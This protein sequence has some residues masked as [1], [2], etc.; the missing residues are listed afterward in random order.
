MFWITKTKYRALV[1]AFSLSLLI[2]VCTCL[3]S[4][5]CAS[6]DVEG[7]VHDAEGNP[8]EGARIILWRSRVRDET[9]TDAEGRYA[10]STSYY[11]RSCTVYAFYDDPR[12]GGYDFLPSARSYGDLEDLEGLENFTLRPAATVEV[13]GQLR[14]VEF[15][16]EVTEYAFSVVDPVYGAL[17]RYDDCGL[18]YGPSVGSLATALGLPP[19]SVAVPAETPF[20]IRVSPPYEA[21]R[22][23]M[24]SSIMTGYGVRDDFPEFDIVEDGGFTLGEGEVLRLDVSKYCL[25]ND[26]GKVEALIERVEGNLT[27]FES[28]GF[29]TAPQRHQLRASRELTESSRIQLSQGMYDDSY[30]DLKEAWLKL[31]NINLKMEGLLAEAAL[32]V[33]VLI[34]FL[35]LTSYS[36]STLLLDSNS[37]KTILS[38]LLFVPMLA[39]LYYVYPGSKAVTLGWFAAVSVVSLVVIL[40]ATRIRPR[41]LN[42]IKLGDIGLLDAVVSVS[43]I[44]KRNLR[45]RR[46]RSGLTLA[47]LLALTMSFVA[48]TSMSSNYGLIY[49]RLEG[50]IPGEDGLTLRNPTYEPKAIYVEKGGGEE[51]GDRM[52]SNIDAGNFHPVTDS[53]VDW[54]L[55]RDDVLGVTSRAESL[56]SIN[57]YLSIGSARVNGVVG[58][59]TEDL[60]LLEGLDECVVEG[61]PLREGGTCL[62]H[63]SLIAKNVTQVGGFLTLYDR[64]TTPFRSRPSSRS[65]YAS[66]RLEVVGAFDDGLME[67]RDTDG[68]GILPQRHEVTYYRS[69]ALVEAVPCSPQEVVVT[70]LSTAMTLGD[71][72][73]SRLVMWLSSGSDPEAVGKGMALAREFRIWVSEVG[74][75]HLAFMGEAIAGKGLPLLIPWGIV[76]LNVLTTM[77]NSM[78]ERKKEINIL[79]SIG[80][81]PL[82]ISGVFLA[83]AMIMGVVAGGL[84]YILGL[85]WYPFMAQLQWAPD[86]QQKISAKWSLAA[87]G[88]SVASVTIGSILAMRG[89]V[90]LTPSLRRRWGIEELEKTHDDFYIMP[91]PL[92]VEEENLYAFVNFTDDYVRGFEDVE[93]TPY[94]IS[95]KKETVEDEGHPRYDI[96]FYYS[97]SGSIVDR[98]FV[99]N[100]IS[101]FRGSEEEAYSVVLKS[102]G[103][104]EAAQQVGAFARRMAFEWA[105]QKT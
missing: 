30:V 47:T 97:E 12:T 103:E 50:R 77:L 78:Y 57:S 58:V 6:P 26:L 44:A 19:N 90:V 83:E 74:S 56:P 68:G 11:S 65:G 96:S 52:W 25:R 59:D 99:Y 60:S 10:L 14:P 72:E 105:A 8:I 39:F 73:V 40:T 18:I 21:E 20:V 75:V 32:S 3:P 29:Y 51:G 42:S 67:V 17:L 92:Q 33:N 100:L 63:V 79:S 2:L 24:W 49:T 28:E 104:K 87:I 76:V 15:S 7:Y 48:L 27:K 31:E 89:S 66:H 41:A 1:L 38:G 86:V 69:T 70:T 37:G 101:I 81:N 35:A 34:V 46:I 85:G 95:V 80:L 4:A 13:Q 22:G 23:W 62:V 88:I 64:G 53:M 94:I 43:S 98:R 36:I 102:K 71:V 5:R 61:E 9:S 16:S 55:K 45:R 54:V 91:L 82:H 93:V 84:G